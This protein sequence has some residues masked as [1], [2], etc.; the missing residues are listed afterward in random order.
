MSMYHQGQVCV[1]RSLSESFLEATLVCFGVA[2]IKYQCK[3]KLREKGHSSR[4]SPA[5]WGSKACRSVE[6]LATTESTI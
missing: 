5:L 1:C 4:Y 3:S 2:V 6:Q